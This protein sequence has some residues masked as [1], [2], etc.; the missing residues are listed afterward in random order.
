[1][2]PSPKFKGVWIPKLIWQHKELSLHA[3]CLWA[4]IDTFSDEEEGCYGSNQYF[5]ELLGISPMGV[6]NII[7][8]LKKLG[9][10]KLQCFDGRKRYLESIRLHPAMDADSTEGLSLAPSA[11]GVS[12]GHY[13]RDRKADKKALP[14]SPAKERP[15]NELFDTLA[16]VSGINLDELNGIIS[17]QI[18]AGLKAI[19]DSCEDVTPDEIK[20]RAYAY[21]KKFTGAELTPTALAKH[22]ATLGATQHQDTKQ[23]I[24]SYLP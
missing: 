8:Q 21:R 10:I 16:N 4:T 20:R 9:L 1:M 24:L 14:K 3:K 5:A 12:N 19:K 7:A 11:D 6:S 18:A 2:N 23:Q 15:R 17:G 22:W 13:I